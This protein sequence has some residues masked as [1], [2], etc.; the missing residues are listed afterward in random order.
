VAGDLWWCSV[1]EVDGLPSDAGVL[2]E[3]PARQP[4]PPTATIQLLGQDGSQWDPLPDTAQT[5]SDGQSILYVH[6]GG[7]V[8][9]GTGSNNQPRL[10]TGLVVQ[11]V[12][13]P[14]GRL[15]QVSA[16]QV[17]QLL[18]LMAQPAHCP[19]ANCTGPDGRPLP[20][21]FNTALIA[22]QPCANAS[23]RSQ[24]DRVQGAIG[25][26]ICRAGGGP[27]TGFVGLLP[28]G[29]GSVQAAPGHGVRCSGFS[30]TDLTTG[31]SCQQF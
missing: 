25:T 16:P 26:T 2:L 19:P 3:V 6:H 31:V 7:T 13:P 17:G 28:F 21:C 18:G 23:I 8:A 22:G 15:A 27:C 1:V 4:L 20:P 29:S 24:G 12:T 5:S 14:A 10:P 11:A 9:A 30:F